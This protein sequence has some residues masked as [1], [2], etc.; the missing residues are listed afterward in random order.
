MRTK[1]PT[2]AEARARYTNRYT[3]EHVPSWARVVNPGN[4]KFYA[5]QFVSDAQ[6]YENTTFPG[7]PGHL[8]IGQDCFTTGAT[9][10]RGQWLDA[11]LSA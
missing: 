9:W 4:G 2:L 11:P 6:W 7:E 3:L 1:R 8:G 10:P 5:P